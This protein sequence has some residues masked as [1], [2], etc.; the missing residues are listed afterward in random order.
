MLRGACR[1]GLVRN[2]CDLD[3]T[4][5]SVERGAEEFHCYG[6][7]LLKP[8][9]TPSYKQKKPLRTKMLNLVR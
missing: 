6:G 4:K 7:S 5:I 8:L 9:E 1:E 2:G 3:V